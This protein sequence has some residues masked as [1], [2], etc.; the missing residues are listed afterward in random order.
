M[1]N[2]AR[3]TTLTVVSLVALHGAF[4]FGLS[5]FLKQKVEE[6]TNKSAAEITYSADVSGYPLN[7]ILTLNNIKAVKAGHDNATI[8]A[9]G[10]FSVKSS[11][12]NPRA[13]T[14]SISGA[15]FS[16]Q[17]DALSTK[18]GDAKIIIDSLEAHGDIFTDYLTSVA[19]KNISLAS[20]QHNTTQTVF[21]LETLT[22]DTKQ[23]KVTSRSLNTTNMIEAKNINLI[24]I[25][26]P[27]TSVHLESVKVKSYGFNVPVGTDLVEAFEDMQE[28][29][30]AKQ[31]TISTAS[32]KGA[33]QAYFDEMVEF[34]SQIKIAEISIESGAFKLN[35]SADLSLDTETYPKGVVNINI[36][37]LSEISKKDPSFD[38]NN[39]M[40]Q[41]MGSDG[42]SI[43]LEIH[44][45]DRM[46]QIGE[47]MK[48]PLFS[49]KAATNF[50]KPT[51]NVPAMAAPIASP[52]QEMPAEMATDSS[53]ETPSSDTLDEAFMKDLS[54]TEQSE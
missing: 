54:T 43:S 6:V 10:N 42:D 16:L 46:L 28:A 13:Y 27:E 12:L 37:G 2:F 51:I 21:N 5:H 18:D 33:L 52:A 9:I 36:A 44:L 30:E 40:L 48:F 29:M 39:P 24:N 53:D 34:S 15:E 4:W 38:P 17:Q 8:N 35:I 22:M 1:K 47:M 45:K 49:L 3:L 20:I 11:L 50:I 19:T 26:K 32:L 23:E 41:M 25:N 7:V 31:E 14:L